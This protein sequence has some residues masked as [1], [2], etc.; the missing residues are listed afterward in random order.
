MLATSPTVLNKVKLKTKKTRSVG[1]TF[2][3]ILGLHFRRALKRK[4]SIAKRCIFD[5]GQLFWTERVLLG[6][7]R[8]GGA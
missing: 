4:K 8:V 5:L 2:H 7:A 1:G 3:A 6:Q